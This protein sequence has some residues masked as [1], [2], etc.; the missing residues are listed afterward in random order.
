M[1]Q[2]ENRRDAALRAAQTC[3]ATRFAGASHIFVAGSIMRG[4][5]NAFSDIDLVVIYPTLDQAWRESFCLDGFPIEAFVHD[6]ETLAHFVEKDVEGGAPVIVNMVAHGLIVGAPGPANAMQQ[7]ARAILAQGPRPLAGISYDT[8]RYFL[9]DLAD[10]L[11]A[12]RPADEIAAIAAQLY[13]RL[14]DLMLLGR[15]QW[16]GKGKWGPRLLRQ[17]DP[18][19]AAHTVAAFRDAV[20]GKPEV[21]LALTDQELAR[22]GGSYFEGYRVLAPREARM[23]MPLKLSP[24]SPAASGQ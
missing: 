5:G 12:E 1:Q 17:F 7:E 16:T 6:A 4:D 20:Q 19:L 10:D 24:A 23:A 3:L 11:R 9:S 14:I 2:Q 13:P 15:H 22:Y 8:M 18:E 21:L